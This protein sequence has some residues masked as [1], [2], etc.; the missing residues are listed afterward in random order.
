MQHIA[1]LQN[2]PQEC[3]S[4]ALALV[5][6]LHPDQRKIP[7]RLSR[8]Q[9]A[10]LIKDCQDVPFPLRRHAFLDERRQRILIGA[11]AR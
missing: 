4:K 5:S 8:V 1:F 6:R 2:R 9:A 11:R 7:V 3:R 10:H